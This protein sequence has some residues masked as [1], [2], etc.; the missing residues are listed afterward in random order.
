MP[1]SLASLHLHIVFSTK[2]R[3]PWLTD[4]YIERLYEYIGGTLRKSKCALIAAGGIPD[5]VH[6]L[7]SMSRELSVAA[8]V[9]LVKSNS[10][11]WIH[12]SFAELAAFNWQS[13]YGAF[14]VSYSN[15]PAV[16]TYLA[17]QKQH[18]AKKSFQTEFRQLLRRHEIEWDEQ[19][20][21]D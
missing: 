4:E 14:A 20:V 18:H 21:W 11:R 6:L 15:I 7:V 3:E 9:Q 17:N 12:D 1:Q 16:Q 19:Y 13:G 2:N 8:V 5:H 10:S